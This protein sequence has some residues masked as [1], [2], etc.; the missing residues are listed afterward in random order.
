MYSA[1]VIKNHK[2]SWFHNH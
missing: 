2:K 1:S